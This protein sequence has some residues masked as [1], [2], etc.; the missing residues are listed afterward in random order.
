VMRCFFLATLGAKIKVGQ[1][2]I[3]QRGLQYHPGDNVSTKESL[4]VSCTILHRSELD[5]IIHCG[6][7][8][9]GL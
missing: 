6:P 5:G 9:M 8:A 1:I 4:C 7:S 3:R 2:I